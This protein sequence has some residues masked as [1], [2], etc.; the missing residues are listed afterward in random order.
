MKKQELCD[1]CTT[2]KIDFN[3]KNTRAILID[4]IF[5]KINI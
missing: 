3:N 1:I 4:K 2:L 5:K